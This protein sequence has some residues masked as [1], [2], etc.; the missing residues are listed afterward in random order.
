MPISITFSG[1]NTQYTGTLSLHPLIDTI[2]FTNQ[3]AIIKNI[4]FPNS[5][6][7]TGSDKDTVPFVKSNKPR[8][9]T[10]SVPFDDNNNFDCTEILTIP[11]NTVI[12]VS[13]LKNTK[14]YI[15]DW[16]KN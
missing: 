16:R 8:T 4:N 13:N 7:N 3:D 9:L 2:S 1:N 10:I 6:P 15:S 5:I 14:R 11:N 12:H